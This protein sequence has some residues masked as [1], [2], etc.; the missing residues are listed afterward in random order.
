VKD[1]YVPE[2]SQYLRRKTAIFLAK[3]GQKNSCFAPQVLRD[4]SETRA[5]LNYT[6]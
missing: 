5:S 4:P 6:Y 2:I 3:F 1:Q